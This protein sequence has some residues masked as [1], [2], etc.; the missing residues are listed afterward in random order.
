MPF[1]K[2]PWNEVRGD[3]YSD[4]GTAV[5]FFD[6]DAAG[7]VQRQLEVYQSGRRLRYDDSHPGD[8]YGGLAVHELD[9]DECRS[10]EITRRVFEEEWN[11]R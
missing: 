2:R 4:W 9:L 3:R 5:Y 6:T 11:Q 10:F 8:E 7:V 1:Y